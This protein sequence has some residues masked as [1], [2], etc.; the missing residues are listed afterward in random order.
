MK[1]FA[2]VFSTIITVALIILLNTSIVLPAPL[3]KLLSPQHGLWQN[4]TP[5]DEDF[6]AVVK[7]GY[8]KG[9]VE[10]YLDERLVPHVFAEHT[11]DAYF[12]QGYLHARFRLWQM[13]FQTMAAG[14]RISEIIG[15]KALNYDREKRRLGMVYAAEKS[16]KDM[17]ADPVSKAQCD[18]YS[19][20]VNGYIKTLTESSLPV[21]YKLTGRKPEKWDNFK[22]ALFL[23]YMSLE[24]A[25]YE[26]DFEN[27]NAKNVFGFA[28]VVSLYPIANDSLDPVIPKGTSFEMPGLKVLPPAS[29][30]SVYFGKQDSTGYSL[31]KPDRDNGSNNWAVAGS[32]TSS[33][34]PILCNDPHLGLN[35]P[36]IWF[37]MQINT[38]EFNA[39]GVT[40]PGAPGVII[41]FNDHIAFGFTNASRDVRDYYQIK[42]RDDSRKEYWFNG[43]WN[44][45]TFRLETIRIKGKPDYVDSVAYTV[46]GPVMFDHTFKTEEYK[47]GHS[48]AVRWKPHDGGNGLRMF[49]DLNRARNYDD[50]LNAIKTFS[51]PG[52]NCIF[53]S[54]NGDI[55]IWQQGAFPAK[56][57]YQ[58]DF[59][60]PGFDS[61]YMWQGD[62]PQEEN[63]HMINPERGFVSSANQL[64]VDT[65]YPYYIGGQ[66]AQD[67]GFIINRLLSRM[68]SV[69]A[70]DMMALQTDNYNVF[71][72]MARPLI[73]DNISADQLNA[74]EK[75]YLDMLRAWDLRNEANSQGTTVFTVSWD[76]LRVGIFADEF[77]KINLPL[78][79]PS[80]NTT[81][82][83]L[84]RDTAFRFIDDVNTASTETLRDIVTRSF[85]KAAKAL[86]LLEVQAKLPYAAYKGTRVTHL[87]NL[88]AFSRL[89]LP[90]GGGSHIINAT[91]TKHGPSW[92]MVVHLTPETEAYGIYPGGQDGNVGSKYYDNFVDSWASGKYYKLWVMKKQEAKDPRVKWRMS[93]LR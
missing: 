85:K 69:T 17:E 28:E 68:D 59:V 52:Q 89:N 61:T 46:F 87:M 6:S 50:Y 7:D 22:T 39:Y 12:V 26:S 65:T 32:R 3:G 76:S 23:E 49:S 18:A 74:S 86:S 16:L 72:E 30:D 82:D 83:I 79:L 24:L 80:E 37:E 93:F 48:Y 20:G 88:D 4:A 47:P 57:K 41:G 25:G 90:I 44:P 19:A 43:D 91:K 15:A 27:T 84:K 5:G 45:V 56:W 1:V 64:P 62:I 67:R 31:P 2:F 34:A 33:G 40:F 81:V 71:A 58:G 63:P 38:P 54:K 77:N 53:A 11:N 70:Q 29:V 66:F 51:T 55:A 21:E 75:R 8:L 13:E 9:K 60:M 36:A 14:G 92:R 35:L 73:V 78:I 10:V 42:F